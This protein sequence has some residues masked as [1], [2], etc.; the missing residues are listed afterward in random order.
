M[1]KEQ[2]YDEQIAP[3][4]TQIIEVCQK[5]GIAMISSFEVPNDIDTDL[6]CST[7][8][9]DETG[10]YPF[11]DV[12]RALRVGRRAPALHLTTKDADGNITSMT[13]VLG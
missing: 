4:M 12:C 6:R 8:L 13:T 7:H 10:K 3:L 9:A 5:H 1:N 2:I 11:A